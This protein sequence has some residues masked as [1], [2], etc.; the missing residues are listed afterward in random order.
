MVDIRPGIGDREVGVYPNGSSAFAASFGVQGSSAGNRAWSLAG[1]RV[2]AGF[3][4]SLRTTSSFP[5]RK[6]MAL[7]A[8]AAVRIATSVPHGMFQQ[9]APTGNR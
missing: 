7:A 2:S 4:P 8:S 6:C 3:G 9:E 5:F 1:L